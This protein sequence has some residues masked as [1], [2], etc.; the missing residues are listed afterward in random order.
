[1]HGDIYILIG[2]GVVFVF[3]ACFIMGVP[4]SLYTRFTLRKAKNVSAMR[5][6]LAKKQ[7]AN[8]KKQEKEIRH[9]IK[10]IAIQLRDS[11]VAYTHRADAAAW[12][13]EHGYEVSDV[14]SPNFVHSFR[15]RWMITIPEISAKELSDIILK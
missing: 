13:K 3:F 6:Y 12:Y 9:E 8:K 5:A 11:G 7:V 15:G 1:M 14:N 10:Y 4:E 2:Y